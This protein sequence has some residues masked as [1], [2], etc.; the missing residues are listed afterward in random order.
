MSFHQLYIASNPKHRNEMYKKWLWTDI[1]VSLSFT[2]VSRWEQNI[3]FMLLSIAYNVTCLKFLFLHSFLPPELIWDSP[4]SRGMRYHLHVRGHIRL[5]NYNFHAHVES[6][7]LFT[8][9]FVILTNTDM[10]KVQN[11]TILEGLEYP[12]L[13]RKG[14][15]KVT[16]KAGRVLSIFLLPLDL[17]WCPPYARVLRY[18]QPFRGHL[19]LTDYNFH[20]HVQSCIMFSTIFVI[21]TN[22]ELHKVQNFTILEG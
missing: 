19:R 20:T 7:S 11:S 10:W 6:V 13:S 14:F 22:T 3:H 1:L 17:I 16:P 9:I 18:H 8:I 4:Y 2:F 21:L 5:T 12:I 15:V